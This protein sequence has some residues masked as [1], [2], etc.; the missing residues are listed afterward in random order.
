VTGVSGA[1]GSTISGSVISGGVFTQENKVSVRISAVNSE[2]KRVVLN[3]IV[4]LDFIDVS[5]LA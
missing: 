4:V 5:M 3:I 2:I 1:S